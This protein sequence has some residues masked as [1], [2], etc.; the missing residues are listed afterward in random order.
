[1]LAILTKNS[2]KYELFQNELER[3]GVALKSPHID[4]PEIQDKDFISAISYKARFAYQNIGPGHLID[5][6]GLLLDAY[7]DFPG[8]L[9]SMILD[10]LGYK[11][12]QRLLRGVPCGAKLV[13]YLGCWVNGK[14]WFWRGEIVGNLV[15][16]D[17]PTDKRVPLSDW[18]IPDEKSSYGV[19][20]HRKRALDALSADLEK[21]Q[22]ELS[23]SVENQI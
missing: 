1:M 5:D 14:L 6:S 11:G 7:P 22:K 21:L 17:L 16:I 19:F 23:I 9:T 18:F 15:P 20:L 2:K 12:M 10:Q 13:C 3:M 8:T 4:I